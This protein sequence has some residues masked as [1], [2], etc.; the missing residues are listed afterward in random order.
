MLAYN[1]IQID[2]KDKEQENDFYN[3][4]NQYSKEQ[5]YTNNL[6]FGFISY[7]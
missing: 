3:Y 6:T 4:T 7:F 5:Q 1:F 2:Y